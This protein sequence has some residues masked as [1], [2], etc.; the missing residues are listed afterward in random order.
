MISDLAL[1]SIL[2]N[3]L[4]PG[5]EANEREKSCIYIDDLSLP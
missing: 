3:S 2:A 4:T 5:H 1:R